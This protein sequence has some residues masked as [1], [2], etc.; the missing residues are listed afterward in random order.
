MVDE[1]GKRKPRPPLDQVALERLALRYVE[2]FATTKAR[3]TRYLNEKVRAR[4][5]TGAPAD[6][7]E[8]AERFS[9][10]GYV[11]DRAFGEARAAM[12]LRRGLGPRRIAGALAAAGLARAD[13]DTLDEAIQRDARNAAMRFAERRRFGPYAPE[14]VGHEDRRKQ[15]AAMVRAGHAFDLAREIIGTVDEECH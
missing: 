15:I 8:I 11:D 4:G 3:L 1:P 5:W 9:L 14:R 6:P 10:L 12:M 13:R 2:R 7:A